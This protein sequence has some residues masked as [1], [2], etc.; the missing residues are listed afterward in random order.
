VVSLKPGYQVDNPES[1]HEVRASTLAQS[2]NLQY[3]AAARLTL[4]FSRGITVTSLTAFRQLDYD[5]FA[6][7]DITELALTATRVHDIQQQWSEEVTVSAERPGLSWVGGVFFLQDDDRQPSPIR[8]EQ[9]RLEIRLDPAVRATS[10]AA[11][12]Q[13]TLAVTR[14]AS[15]TAGLRYTG[16]RKSIDDAGGVHALGMPS[17]PAPGSAYAYSDSIAHSAWTPK[18]AL[19]LRGGESVLGYLSAT[20]GFKSGG[21]NFTSTEPGRGYDPEWAWSYEAGL[22]TRL[23][24]GRARLSLAAFHTDYTDLQVQTIVR[25][26]VLDVSNAAAATIRGL[27]VEGAIDP[28]GGLQAGGTWPGCTPLTTSTRRWPRA[29]SPETWPGT[30]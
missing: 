7:S 24:G 23:G 9:P 12:G 10:G 15:L 3:G 20:R 22:K 28:T 4:R 21:F 11:F 14:R 27:E 25:P 13:A 1:L 5:V 16:E 19:E 30:G 29:A 26:G 17:A 2:R 8:L 6:D 18:V